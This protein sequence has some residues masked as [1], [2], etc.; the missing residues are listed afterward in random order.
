MTALIVLVV[1]AV[2]GVYAAVVALCRAAAL[3]DR[4]PL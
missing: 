1:L 3:G 4:R 2:I